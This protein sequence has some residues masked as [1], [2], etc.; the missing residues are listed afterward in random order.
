MSPCTHLAHLVWILR[1]PMCIPIRW[2]ELIRLFLLHFLRNPVLPF[3]TSGAHSHVPYQHVPSYLLC[4]IV[5][6]SLSRQA[7]KN[8]QLNQHCHRERKT[9]HPHFEQTNRK[10]KMT[11]RGRFH[12][13]TQGHQQSSCRCWDALHYCPI[14]LTMSWQDNVLTRQCLDHGLTL[15]M[16]WPVRQLWRHIKLWSRCSQDMVKTSVLIR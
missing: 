9:L 10:K 4:T 11:N 8:W 5:L 6:L 1:S 7:R 13:S 2:E 12:W 14:V 3:L 16:S 15:N